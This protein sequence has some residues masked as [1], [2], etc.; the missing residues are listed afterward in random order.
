VTEPA[1]G[2]VLTASDPEPP[3]G[4]VVLC[5]GEEWANFGQA[6][7]SLDPDNNGRSE[8]WQTIASRHGPVTVTG[9]IRRRCASEACDE[10]D[11]IHCYG[12][13]CAMVRRRD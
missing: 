1:I 10:Y 6:W 7:E 13:G 12:D 3:Q 4:T 11:G 8:Y 5:D 2:A 9:F